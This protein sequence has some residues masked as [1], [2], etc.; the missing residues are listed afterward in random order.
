MVN[1]HSNGGGSAGNSSGGAHGGA[2]GDYSGD[3]RSGGEERERLDGM[4][5]HDKPTYL[6]EH[7]ATFTVNKESGIVYPADGMRRLLQLEKTTGIWSQKMQ[8]CLD[9]QWVLIM[10]YETGNI[11]ERF[12]ASLVQEPT[13]F[14]SNDAMELYNNI[15]V[16]IVSGGGGSRSE[17]H[18]F[19][20]QSVSA[21]HLVEDLKQLRSG[22]MITQQRGATPTQH[23][24]GASG[25]GMAAMMM[26]KTSSSSSHSRIEQHHQRDQRDRERGRDRERER[27]RER[28]LHVQH[29]MHQ[30]SSVDQYGMRGSGAG[31]VTDVD[32]G[33][34]GETDSEHGCVN[35]RDETSSTSSEKYERDVAVLNHC[36]DD[37]EKFI[38]RLQHA[39]AAS[40][41]LE[42]RRRNRKSKKRDPGEGLLTLRTRP[43]HEKEFVDIFAKFKLSFNLLAKLKAHI[44][45]PNAPELVHFLFTP[46]ALIVEASSD[47]YYESQ[48]P[49]RVVNP[50]LTREA[51]NLLINCVTS[52]ETELWRSLGDAWVIPRDQWKE[53]VGSYHPVFLDG[54][55]P[56]YLVIDELEATSP[57]HVSKRRLDVQPGPG[58]HLSGLN[59]RGATGG[60]D[61]YD[62]NG[63]GISLSEK[64][65]IHHGN[66]R[67]RERERDR[68]GAISASDFNARSELSFD[69]IERGSGGGGGGGISSSG[70]GH[71]P[72]AG[73][74]LS[75][76]TAGLQNLHTRDSRNVSSSGGNYGA[77]GVGGGVSEISAVTA[78]GVANANATEDQLLE[79]WLE[80]LQASGAK[81]VLVTYPRT[82]NNDK[83]LSVMRGEYLEILDDTRKWWKA[84]NIRGQVAHVP[85]TIVTPFN[86]GDGDGG[87]GQFYG[88]Q[89]QVAANKSRHMSPGNVDNPSMDQ[90]SPDATDMIRSKHLG[91]KGEFRYF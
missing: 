33:P 71:G 16:F 29:H 26:S 51:I 88:Q 62:T 69:S 34:N 83:E 36:F 84:R 75:A 42:R 47:T 11:I 30:R 61:D 40:R 38:A 55:S 54:W 25:S 20:S 81:I 31:A 72:T 57:T 24:S 7:L 19:Q 35:D 1:H 4:D 43:P 82:A 27:E 22:K 80:D 21:V 32:I 56:D 17:M 49:S 8:L 44:H 46:L 89:Q 39:A 76:I 45:D 73:P 2:G 74:T 41:E 53:D 3:D 86:Y 48:L 64:Y 23:T 28:D 12:P 10:D 85:H 14:T 90:R 5:L 9:Y 50:L 58:S 87:N 65:T 66:D 15:L 70:A 91:K 13:A 63:I 67:D 68:S 60:Y 78:R 52:K 37:I 77:S 6:L 79:A 18:I 59:G